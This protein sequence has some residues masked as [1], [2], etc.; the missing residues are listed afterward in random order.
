MAGILEVLYQGSERTTNPLLDQQ[1]EVHCLLQ[2]TRIGHSLE[3]LLLLQLERRTLNL[4]PI[5]HIK[6]RH[7]WTET[8]AMFNYL[9]KKTALSN[10]VLQKRE[11]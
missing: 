3:E 1:S 7:N 8:E 4:K 2:L 11:S 9:L 10:L 6:K 5:Q